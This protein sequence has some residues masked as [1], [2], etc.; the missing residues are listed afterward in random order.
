MPESKA[1]RALRT[2]SELANFCDCGDVRGRA[3][4]DAHPESQGP[5]ETAL[6]RLT[7]HL[8]PETPEAAQAL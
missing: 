3:W 1:D 7:D 8:H 6:H 2:R 4:L 5:A